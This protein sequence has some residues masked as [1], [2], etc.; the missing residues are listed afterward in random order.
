MRSAA[1][2]YF[3]K[4]ALGRDD[5]MF[6]GEALGLQAMAGTAARAGG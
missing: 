6:Q 4:T 2:S 1:Q 3:V 5:G